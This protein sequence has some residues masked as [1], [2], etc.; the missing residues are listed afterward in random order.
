MSAA[1]KKSQQPAGAAPPRQ[2][3]PG[4]P[5]GGPGGHALVMPTAKAKDLRGALR[6]LAGQLKPERALLVTVVLLAVVSVTFAVVGPKILGRATNIIFDGVIS[7]QIPA[8]VTKAQ[9]ML[10]CAPRV[11][12]ASP[13]CSPA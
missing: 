7:K 8:G 13:N 2:R 11:R 4:G 3:G 9:A 10:A 5:G 6:R 12:A 1:E